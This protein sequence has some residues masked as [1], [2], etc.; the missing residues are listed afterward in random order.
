MAR[1]EA[2]E[3][4]EANPTVHLIPRVVHP[5]CMERR[6][7]L[8]LPWAVP[9][10]AAAPDPQTVR[11]RLIQE[12][13]R[14][15]R[16]RTRS[17]QVVE[18]AGDAQTVAVLR[19]DRLGKEDFEAAGHFTDPTHFQ[20]DPIYKRALFVYRGGKRLVVT[21]WCEI[22]AIRTYAPGE[23]QCCHNETALDPRDPSLDNTATVPSDSSS[24][25][26]HAVQK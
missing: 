10:W 15:P 21:Y 13:S 25:S 1:A 6:L 26:P 11:G 2:R 16:I 24:T 7:F 20:V 14:P 8:L 12:E 4:A 19:D 23:C 17:G 9:V 22:C 5:E 3:L 18:L